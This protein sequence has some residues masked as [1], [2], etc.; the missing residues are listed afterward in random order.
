M[1]NDNTLRDTPLH[2]AG[3]EKL[4]IVQPHPQADT[5]FA[6]SQGYVVA[7]IEPAYA[8][9]AQAIVDAINAALPDKAVGRAIHPTVLGCKGCNKT[10]MYPHHNG[11]TRCESGSIAS[12]GRNSHCS[13]DTCF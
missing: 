2:L 6:K 11:S 12:G 8:Q 5:E 4:I 10:G 1:S 13:C 7:R 9:Y 3:A